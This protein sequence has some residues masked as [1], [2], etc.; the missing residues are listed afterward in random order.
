MSASTKKGGA[1]KAPKGVVPPSGGGRSG[2]LSDVIVELGFASRD[3]VEEAVRAARSPGTTV[4]RE[5]VDSGAITEE[6]L[7]RATAE[8]YGIDYID[9]TGFEVDP[10]AANLIKPTAARRYQAV[11]VA[12][13]GS[14]L[15]VAM[16]DP[17]DALGVNDI[18]VMTKLEVRPA[19][20]SRPTLEA[21]LDALPLDELGWDVESVRSAAREPAEPEVEIEIEEPASPAFFW[22]DG[23]GEELPDTVVPPAPEAGEA[24]RLRD[25][26]EALKHQLS[27]AEA[28]LKGERKP[29]DDGG[30]VQL[31][32]RL[33]AAEA[34]LEAARDRVREAKEV[35]AELESLREKLH[36]AE[37][38]LDQASARA[39]ESDAAAA[40]AEELRGKVTR[41]RHERDEL[42]SELRR[43][44]ADSDVRTGELETLRAK[45]TSAE[46]ELVRVRA[47][48]DTRASE[49]EAMRTRTESAEREAED[50]LRRVSEAEHQMDEARRR[51]VEL[52]REASSAQRL[53]DELAAA[54]ARAEQARQALTQMREEGERER[55]QWAMTERE[56]REQLGDEE[57]RRA[58]LERQLSEVE[59]AAFAA[60]RSFEE[61]RLAQRRM[62]G[63][64]RA[65]AEPDAPE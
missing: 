4:A 12:Y 29:D 23:A 27:G 28:K 21:L 38:G 9:L 18:A 14:G 11:P 6:Q 2:F 24:S 63:A 10:A 61:L 31:R 33:A 64:L 65:L 15:L 45:L 46:T 35:G 34:E 16:A 37:S 25:E 19:V 60:E 50:A 57:R 47:E 56:L 54:D 53:A 32:A 17:A 41:L 3:T 40:E 36:A 22:Q 13:L 49:L 62:R 20:A 26:L 1:D 30:G 59:G 42:R 8:R 44:S 43:V 5:L 51:A 52:E 39:R 55:E 48:A 7:A 58:E